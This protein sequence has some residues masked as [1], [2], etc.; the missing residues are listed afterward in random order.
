MKINNLSILTFISFLFFSTAIFAQESKIDS[1]KIELQ[2]H[3]ERDTTR[4]DVLYDLAFLCFRKDLSLTNSYLKKAEIISDSL[5]YKKGKANVLSLKGIL[6]NRK[7]NYDN[8]LDYF[9][10]SLQIFKFINDKKGIASSY[11]SIGVTHL[12]QSQNK[13]ALSYLKKSL[14]IYEE[15][16]DK[17]KLVAGYMNLGSV[18]SSLGNYLE[19]ISYYK[20]A[21]AVS[22]EINHEYGVPYALSNLGKVY[23]KQ[24]NIAI[25][26]DYYSEG[27]YYKEKLGDT[28]GMSISMNDLGSM[29]RSIGNFDKALEYHNKSLNFALKLEN[30]GIIAINKENIG[31]IYKRK[32]EYEKALKYMYESLKISQEIKDVGQ[33]SVC[34]T[35]IGEVNL[36]LKKPLIARENFEKSNVI[37]LENG[38]Q[39]VTISNYLG[40]SESYLD[41]KQYKKALS[42]A[43]KGKKIAD[44]LNLYDS[45]HKA[46]ELLSNIY[47]N[48]GDYKK[49]LSS[50]Q[51]FKI[52][53]DSLL[54]KKSVEKITQLEYE[55]KYKQELELA[56]FR[57]LK[58]TKT[59]TATT[60]D[61][62]KSKQNYLWAIIG[63]LLV[64]ILLGSIIFYQK[65]RNEKSKTQNIV[66]EQKLLR[67]QMTPHFIFNS[68][69]VLQGMILNKEEK[70]SILYLS[71]FSKLLR[72]TLEN[73]RDKTVPLYEEL[74]AINNYLE[75]QNLEAS[76]S[77]QY[78]ILVDESIDES[79]LEIPPMLVQPFIENAIE[80]GFK[81][82]KDNRK[83]DLQLKYLNKQLICTITDNGIGVDSFVENKKQHKK[84]LSTTITS[85]RIKMLSKDFKMK[86]S[87]TI[88][89]RQKYKEQGTIVTLIIPYKIIVA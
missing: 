74:T 65:F 84:S 60:K 3:K 47:K 30:K 75:L 81:D 15:I 73:S 68:L 52:L 58:L 5:D 62:E 25:A 18:N 7:S 6:A 32:K 83:I 41:E 85:E 31:L 46:L 34:L 20:K 12:Q 26:L 82:K 16:H 14:A 29:Y 37:S 33:E 78:T 64:S 63:A 51:Q 66:I 36:L 43:W 76:Q 57:E 67:S 9:Q 87:V 24:G 4:V 11:N 61:L 17:K 55:Y 79:L 40:L 42:F 1:L 80:H 54:S 89:D 53:S 50:Y 77:Y 69:S 8:G 86:G 39:Y 38:E 19:A 22:K 10:Q 2:N 44:E 28:L 59:V 72:I 48:T 71:K 70:K 23:K 27:L 21:L 45:Q 35:N 56:S 49:A 88:E 13:E